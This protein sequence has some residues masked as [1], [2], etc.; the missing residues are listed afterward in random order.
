MKTQIW[1]AALLTVALAALGSA[2]GSDDSRTEAASTTGVTSPSPDGAASDD[3]PTSDGEQDEPGPIG[4]YTDFPFSGTE[5][6]FDTGGVTE[7]PAGT[8]RAEFTVAPDAKWDHV[9][10]WVRVKEGF[11]VQQVLDA[12][13]AD[14]TGRTA[15]P[16]LDFFGGSNALGAGQTQVSYLQLEPGT[17]ILADFI[18]AQDGTL[19][20][21]SARGL[22]KEITVTEPQKDFATFNPDGTI[23]LKDMRFQLPDDFDGN[24]I[25]QVRNEDDVLHETGIVRLNDGATK[26]DVVEFFDFSKGPPTGPPPY[27]TVG[28]F[29]ANNTGHDGYIELHLDPG[30]YAFISFI[31]DESFKQQLSQG[32]LE[33]FTVGG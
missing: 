1:R 22:W 20:P 24:G 8:V 28:G 13:A 31:T 25:F 14:F 9:A 27:T 4:D 30:N 19:E 5:Y 2:C 7:I 23:L 29:G 10:M 21:H 11:T 26:D 3:Q 6:E 12:A 17:Y 32:M 33:E 18:P 15:E 16:M